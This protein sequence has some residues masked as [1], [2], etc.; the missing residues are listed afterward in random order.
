MPQIQSGESKKDWLSRCMGDPS[1]NSE[2]PRQ[3]QRYA[4]CQSKWSQSKKSI[5][6]AYQGTPIWNISNIDNQIGQ[7][8]K[9]ERTVD[10]NLSVTFSLNDE[11]TKLLQKSFDGSK[12]MK[13]STLAEYSEAMHMSW[14]PEDPFKKNVEAF[15]EQ[16]Y[17]KLLRVTEEFPAYKAN[18]FRYGLKK[19]V[20]QSQIIAISNYNYEEEVPPDYTTFST[21]DEIVDGIQEATLLI[22]RGQY[23]IAMRISEGYGGTLYC[24]LYG[25]DKANLMA[26]LADLKKGMKDNNYL[27]GKKLFANGSFITPGKFTWD[28][29]I[30]PN[31]F[32]DKIEKNIIQFLTKAEELKAKGLPTKRGLLIYGEPGNGKS[33]LGKVLANEVPCTFIWVPY[34]ASMG[35]VYEMA[36]E[37]APSVVFLEDLATQG[38]L[39]R[40]GGISSNQLGYLLNILDGVEENTNVVTVATE[41]FVGHLDIALRNRPGRFDLILHLGNPALEQ[42]ETFLKR[43]LPEFAAARIRSLAQE[44]EN[45]SCA[46]LRELVNRIIIEDA[47]PDRDNTIIKEMR[48]CFAVPKSNTKYKVKDED[49]EAMKTLIDSEQKEK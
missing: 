39:D 23:K 31:G 48:E 47:T 12:P 32:R 9:T 22:D 8:I 30:L 46:H 44:T 33:S 37:L 27:K 49:Y 38:G 13:D 42:R 18:L 17:N 25:T 11:G 24:L 3:D 10:G 19:T 34:T 36:N 15:L 35:S 26:F 43:Y 1:M 7:V 20:L 28:D 14:R 41:N 21:G 6:D 29:I 4:V 16:P 40:R 2:F 45:F 5:E